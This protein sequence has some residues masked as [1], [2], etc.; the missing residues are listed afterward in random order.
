MLVVMCGMP[1]LGHG[2]RKLGLDLGG[3]EQCSP[4]QFLPGSL[5]ELRVLGPLSRRHLEFLALLKLV[6][7][8]VDAAARNCNLFIDLRASWQNQTVEM[9]YDVQYI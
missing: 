2:F 5:T 6:R 7:G 9:F 3:H 1:K 4:R 8:I